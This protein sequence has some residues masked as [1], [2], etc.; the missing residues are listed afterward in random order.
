MGILDKVEHLNMKRK[1]EA[2]LEKNFIEAG[3]RN[4]CNRDFLRKDK[5]SYRLKQINKLHN[6]NSRKFS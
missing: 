5:G 1:K 6:S 2:E 3:F 4:I